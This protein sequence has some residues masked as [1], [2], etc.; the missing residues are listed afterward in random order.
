VQFSAYDTGSFYDEMF[1][2]GALPRPQ[3]QLLLETITSLSAGQL[4]RYKHAAERMLLQLGITFDVYG[5]SSDYMH[6]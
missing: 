4:L 6:A 5:D 2:E 1:E 3:T